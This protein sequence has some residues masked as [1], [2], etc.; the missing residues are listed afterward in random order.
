MKIAY[1]LWAEMKDGL[2]DCPIYWLPLILG[3]LSMNAF[4]EF[5]PDPSSGP[6]RRGTRRGPARD[7]PREGREH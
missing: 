1:D 2:K 7:Y 3:S 5:L 6:G 4:A